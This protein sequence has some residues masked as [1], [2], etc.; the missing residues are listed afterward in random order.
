MMRYVLPAFTVGLVAVILVDRTRPPVSVQASGVPAALAATPPAMAP[1]SRGPSPANPG[2][3]PAPAPASATPTLDRL[4]RL[5]VRQQLGREA[6]ATYLDSLLASTDSVV[7]RWPD[8]V[9][10]LKVALVEGGPA[11]YTPHLAGLFRQA[12]ARWTDA[13]VGVRF[14]EVPDTA[15]AD[16]V[17]HWIDRFD[18]DRAGQTDLTWDQQG[19]VRRAAVSLALRTSTGVTFNDAA[20]L[21]VAVHEAGHAIGLPHSAD[22][23][24]VMFPSTRTAGL[25]ARDIRT[26]AVLYQLPP[27]SVRDPR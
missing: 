19:R 5:A 9:S 6:G 17:V 2:T 21:A 8:L 13:G 25:S 3:A 26:A 12:L 24:D 20:L 15:S 16:I 27:G 14:T 1:G 11:D 7:R 18:F 4:A 10:P 23:S 22:S